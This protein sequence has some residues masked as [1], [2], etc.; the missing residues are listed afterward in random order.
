M[1]KPT[2]TTMYP[3]TNVTPPQGKPEKQTPTQRIKMLETQITELIESNEKNYEY[4]KDTHKELQDTR[5]LLLKKE[6]TLKD[7]IKSLSETFDTI[8]NVL[9]LARKAL[10]HNINVNKTQGK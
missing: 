5:E 7:I 2:E 4:A 8:E 6:Q 1:E 3:D 10:S 9:A